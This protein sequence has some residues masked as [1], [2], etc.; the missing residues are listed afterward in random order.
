MGSPTGSTTIQIPSDSLVS[1]PF[2]SMSVTPDPGGL[3]YKVQATTVGGGVL[4]FE[5]KIMPNLFYTV[6]AEDVDNATNMGY[7]LFDI[8]TYSTLNSDSVVLEESYFV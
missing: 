4:N 3:G 2:S 8:R 5:A 1:S 6:T 7:P